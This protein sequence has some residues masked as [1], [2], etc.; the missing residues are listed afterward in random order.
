M[1]KEDVSFR[2]GYRHEGYA[3]VNI[4]VPFEPLHVSVS[5]LQREGEIPE[6]L[7]ADWIEANVSD[8]RLDAIF[9]H[10][11]AAEYEYFTDW[12]SEILPGTTFEQ[13]GRSG[14]WAVS[15]HSE[16]DVEGWDAVTLAK[17]GKIVRIGR[18]I[19]SGVS[20]QVVMSIYLNEYA[21]DKLYVDAAPVGEIIAACG[22]Q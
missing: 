19:A 8:D 5:T 20:A 17:W 18:E 2:R 21:P 10:E 4:K 15:N 9:W 12:A 22:G 13:D 11:C 1:R 3:C 7:T 16:Y 14:G 6:T